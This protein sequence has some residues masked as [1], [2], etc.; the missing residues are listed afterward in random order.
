MRGDL[1]G[2][3]GAAGDIRGDLGVGVAAAEDIRGDLGVGVG[4][5]GVTRDVRGTPGG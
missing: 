5:G 3:G 2:G 1:G 4:R